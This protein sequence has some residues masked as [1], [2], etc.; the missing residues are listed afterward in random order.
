MMSRDDFDFSLFFNPEDGDSSF[1]WN[2]GVFSPKT[3]YTTIYSQIKKSFI[4]TALR[5]SSVYHV[6][7]VLQP[8]EEQL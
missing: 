6:S 8:A 7:E 2:V 3:E 5:C 4:T 1:V